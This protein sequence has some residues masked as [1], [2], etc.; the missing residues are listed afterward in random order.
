MYM[1]EKNLPSIGAPTLPAPAVDDLN[2]G[3]L[4]PA[5]NKAVV[6]VAPY[7]GMANGDRLVLNWRGLDADGIPSE[8]SQVRH[9][10]Q[11]QSGRE[12]VFVIKGDVIAAL[13][14]GSV[15][16]GWTLCSASLSEPVLSERRSLVIGDQRPELLAPV[17]EEAVGG[18]LDPGRVPHGT[19][20]IIRPYAR[21]AA[22]DR[23]RLFWRGQ[24]EGAELQDVLIVEAFSVGATL[25]MW[26]AHDRIAACLGSEVA[27]GYR[28]EQEDGTVRLSEVARLTIAPLVREALSAP[29]VL[30]ADEGVLNEE[31]SLDGITV[32][33]G[34][35]QAESGELVYLMC[36]G[37]NFNHRDYREITPETAWQ[38][39]VFIVPYRFWREHLDTT[40]RVSYSVE[41]L[42][43]V[44]QV[45]EV[46]LVQV[47]G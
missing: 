9:V 28:V 4:D 23:I 18:A 27:V 3:M 19:A 26:I 6:T 11:G 15:E 5:L 30:G 45:S 32:V 37:E 14:G 41:R 10:S 42:D 21:M 43:D 44:S 24:G 35:A 40:V 31:D 1:D 25:S 34:N 39:L 12:V 17:V 8:H 7:R 20:V 2:E 47:R 29:E 38:P 16:V 36:D 22:G 33:I 13:E 46:A